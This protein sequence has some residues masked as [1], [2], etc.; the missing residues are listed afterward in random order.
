MGPANL[1]VAEVAIGHDVIGPARRHPAVEV[2]QVREISVKLPDSI[3]AE[4]A[5]VSRGDIPR[6]TGQPFQGGD[7]VQVRM[8]I[9]FAVE[10]C[11]PFLYLDFLGGGFFGPRGCFR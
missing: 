6:G 7:S 10:T 8:A 5:L 9:S 4:V 2:Q 1:A 3:T 11:P